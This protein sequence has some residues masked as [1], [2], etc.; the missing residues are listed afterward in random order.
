MGS[1]AVLL[2][3]AHWLRFVWPDSGNADAVA[4]DTTLL[5]Y[6]QTINRL[7]DNS[8]F[9]ICI[10]Q[11]FD[12][13]RPVFCTFSTVREEAF[14]LF[15]SSNTTGH[16]DGNCAAPD[17][18]FCLLRMYLIFLHPY[19][20]IHVLPKYKQDINVSPI[21]NCEIDKFVWESSLD[22]FK[23]DCCFTY[24]KDSH[25][26]EQSCRL[27]VPITATFWLYS[28]IDMEAWGH[29]VAVVFYFLEILHFRHF[30]IGNDHNFERNHE[31]VIPS[32]LG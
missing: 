5:L 8:S 22:S 1:T 20:G 18:K 4:A 27:L 10:S 12:V 16:Q 26:N 31:N 30:P 32:N 7:T 25:F 29:F 11:F 19:S 15:I 6:I 14:V 9:V 28:N 17:T 23:A 24:S 2:S 21:L 3:P 13:I